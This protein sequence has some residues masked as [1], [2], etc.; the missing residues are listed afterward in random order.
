MNA[1]SEDYI[2]DEGMNNAPT[3]TSEPP[4]FVAYKKIPRYRRDIIITEKIDGTNAVIHIAESGV[5]TAGSRSRW[6]APGKS[7]DNHG[8]AQW[9]E[10]H[11][12]ELLVLGPGYTFGEWYGSGINRGYGLKNGEK[13]FALFVDPVD[14]KGE[15]PKCC[16]I[17]P[18]LYEGLRTEEMI[19]WCLLALRTNGSYAVPGFMR[20]EGIVIFDTASRGLHKITLENDEM[21]KELVK[22]N[23]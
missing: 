3:F 22:K 4:E 20:P 10:D 1:T 18:R 13:H 6:I 8:F 21:P 2:R 12:E 16:E 11:Y 14:R 23:G 19:E 9:V 17:T 5:M 15:L 7:T